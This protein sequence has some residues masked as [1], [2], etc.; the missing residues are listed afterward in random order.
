MIRTN[1]YHAAEILAAVMCFTGQMLSRSMAAE[2][3][4]LTRR[5]AELVARHDKNGDGRLDAAER[6]KMRLALKEERLKPGSSGGSR[7]PAEVL[8]DYDTN[9]DGDMED[10]EWAKARVAEQAILT[11]QFDADRDG[12]L[13][14]Q[15]IDAMMHDIR[16]KRVRYARDYFA[17]MLKYDRND[18]GRFDGEEY[19]TAQATEG[20]IVE[21][22]YDANANGAFDKEEMDKLKADLKQG[23]IPGFYAR[24]ASEVAHGGRRGG[25]YLEEK[26]KILVFDTNG[27]GI[28]SAE[29]LKRARQS[30]LRT[31]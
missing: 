22:T 3:S 14:G 5:R 17:Y 30:L 12:S 24:F 21:K 19:A 26:K 11:K 1:R 13:N 2:Q 10:S 20:A 8:A 6:E 23:T 18:N 31:Q 27:D 28:A 9:K 29:E 7:V 4:A 16:T 25:G 15:E